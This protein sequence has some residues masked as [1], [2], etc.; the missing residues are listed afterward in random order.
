MSYILS[1]PSIDEKGLYLVKSDPTSKKVIGK[2]RP[3]EIGYLKT[4]ELPIYLRKEIQS[5]ETLENETVWFTQTLIVSIPEEKRYEF[6]YL[7]KTKS[8]QVFFK[9]F[10]GQPYPCSSINVNDPEFVKPKARAKKLPEN[11]FLQKG[12]PVY[13]VDPATG[14]LRRFVTLET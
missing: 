2:V 7:Y 4:I 11:S 12:I 8:G 14:E 3:E 10:S 1:S 9:D 5:T 6:L 13:Q